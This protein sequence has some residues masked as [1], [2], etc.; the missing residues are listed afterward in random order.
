MVK[1]ISRRETAAEIK[2]FIV[3]SKLPNRSSRIVCIEVRWSLLGQVGGTLGLAEVIEP[4]MIFEINQQASKEC[5]NACPFFLL[6]SEILEIYNFCRSISLTVT[7]QIANFYT[8]K[9]SNQVSCYVYET[10]GL[11]SARADSFL[12]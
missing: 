5:E 7:V 4:L 11:V 12:S 8:P 2:S 10:S 3:T 1:P 6:P 9:V